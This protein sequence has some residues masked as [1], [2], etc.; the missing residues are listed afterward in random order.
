MLRDGSGNTYVFR[1]TAF[2]GEHVPT[3]DEA[4]PLIVKDLKLVSAYE[5]AKKKAVVVRDAAGSAAANSP[6][7][8][9]PVVSPPVKVVGPIVLDNR[10]PEIPGYDLTD[11]TVQQALIPGL[12]SLLSQ[13]K[14]DLPHPSTVVDMPSKQKVLALEL[15]TYE[16]PWTADED[17]RMQMQMVSMA[18]SQLMRE[19]GIQDALQSWFDAEAVATRMNFKKEEK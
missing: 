16:R 12:F 7:G 10:R 1:L 6:I 3:L 15:R 11:P 18:R 8:G 17:A 19:Q 5:L 13:A 2:E 14:G 9:L 4:R